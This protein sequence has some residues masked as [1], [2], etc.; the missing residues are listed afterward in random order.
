MFVSLKKD[1]QLRGCIGTIEPETVC[2]ADE[3]IENAIS[4]GTH[5]PRFHSVAKEELGQLLYSVDVLGKPERVASVAELDA[6]TIWSDRFQRLEAWPAVAKSWTESTRRN[7]RFP[8]PSRKQGF[9][10]RRSIRSNASR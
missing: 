6:K 4:A 3:I 2:V 1:G 8:L 10:L 9:I 7:S 5:D